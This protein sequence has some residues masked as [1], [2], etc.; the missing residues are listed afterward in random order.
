MEKIG[1]AHVIKVGKEIYAL[2]R[3]VQITHVVVL[4]VFIIFIQG[5]CTSLDGKPWE[6][7]CNGGYEGDVC[8]TKTCNRSTICQNGGIL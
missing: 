1:N 3:H 8:Q 4:T 2:S 6:C 7:T 5:K